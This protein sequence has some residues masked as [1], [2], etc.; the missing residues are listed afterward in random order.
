MQDFPHDETVRARYAI[1]AWA[2]RKGTRA[3]YP[4]CL[5]LEGTH[6]SGAEREGER[7]AAFRAGRE[8]SAVECRDCVRATLTLIFFPLF[9]RLLAPLRR[10]YPSCVPSQARHLYFRKACA[11]TPRTRACRLRY[12]TIYYRAVPFKVG[13][14]TM[15]AHLARNR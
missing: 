11:L 2:R 14:T 7:E 12:E 4:L 15:N 9:F 5:Y 13:G 1:R 3:R 8:K 6:S 10:L